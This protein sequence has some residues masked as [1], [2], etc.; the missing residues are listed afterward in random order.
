MALYLI[1]GGAGFIGSNL[2]AELVQ[3]GEAVRVLDNYST[4]RRSN[5]ASIADRV[6]LIEGDL[7]S[8]HQ[9]QEAVKGVDFVLHQ[10]ALPSVPRS[11]RDPIT[12]NEVNVLGTLN[13]LQ[14]ARDAGVKRLVYAS[15]SSVYGDNPELP[16][17]ESMCPR[18]L[19]PYAISK[20][21][22][23]QYCQ[24]FWRLY[25][26]ETVCL[27]YFNVFGPR[28][29]PASQ[30]AAVIPRFITAMLNGADAIIYGDGRQSRD[31]TFIANVVQANLRACV[32]PNAA[33]VVCNIACGERYTLLELVERLAQITGLAPSVR[34]ADPRPGDVP[35]S[36]ADISEARTRLGYE[37]EVDLT[38]GLEQTVAWLKQGEERGGR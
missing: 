27:R 26:F 28:Q 29:D 19:S 9:V 34:H 13:I 6:E 17:R 2:A 25:G 14:A 16:K 1:T 15:S 37:P 22:G 36:Q 31:F 18:P 3:R 4:G 20:L 8:Y 35:H 33:G 5:L 10:G 7:R 11:V 21:A 23:E 38:T 24:A 30:Y 12:T 32:A